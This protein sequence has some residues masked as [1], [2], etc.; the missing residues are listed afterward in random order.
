MRTLT[1]MHSRCS[2]KRLNTRGSDLLTTDKEIAES[3]S[4]IRNDGVAAF[5]LVRD[6]LLSYIV[7]RL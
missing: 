1:Q 6:V 7:A 4:V 5:F 3:L 2:R